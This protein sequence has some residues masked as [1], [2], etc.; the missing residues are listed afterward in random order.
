MSFADRM[1]K[2][3]DHWLEHNTDHAATYRQWAEKARENGMDAVAAQLEE[4]ARMTLEINETFSAA[5]QSLK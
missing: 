2:L 1:E 3:L 5:A 4:A